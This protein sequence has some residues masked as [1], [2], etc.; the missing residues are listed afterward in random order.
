MRACNFLRVLSLY[1]LVCIALCLPVRFVF[2]T[3]GDSGDQS[4]T[5]SQ[6]LIEESIAQASSTQVFIIGRDFIRHNCQ[7]VTSEEFHGD[8][9]SLPT[10]WQ[11]H[12]NL[13]PSH[14]SSVQPTTEPVER[15]G[16]QIGTRYSWPSHLLDKVELSVLGTPARPLLTL[17]IGDEFP[18]LRL[19]VRGNCSVVN[20]QR[21]EYRRYKSATEQAP[22]RMLAYQL[23]SLDEQGNVVGEP[24][25][26][27]PETD[28]VSVNQSDVTEA[29]SNAIVPVA[30]IDSGVN[31]LL[32][33]IA[34]R[35]L[36]DSSGQMAGY[37]YWD[38]D[39]RPFDL[40][41]RGSVFNIQRHGTRT[42]S[43]LMT[44][45]P[46]AR[47]APFRFPR[48]HMHRMRELIAHIDSLDIRLVGMA[49]GGNRAEEWEVFEQA[50]KQYP[51][52]LFVVSAGM[53]WILMVRKL[54]FPVPATPCPVWWLYWSDCKLKIRIG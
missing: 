24:Q 42:A 21:V 2:A 6:R 35:L 26:L 49:L 11:A 40:N 5:E 43:L 27:N 39:D 22:S 36:R 9:I 41:L 13:D 25:L 46:A 37:D 33:E 14:D 45:A 48:P 17:Q 50:A 31:Y 54:G 7:Q 8:T 18:V 10:A 12:S 53:Y 28:L 38:N 44:E 52:M 30:M 3:T 32:P 23:Q 15:R 34:D 20:A 51:Q 4:L 19:L 1:L 16:Q 47:V 29:D